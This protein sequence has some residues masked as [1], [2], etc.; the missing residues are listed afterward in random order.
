MKRSL[1]P[2]LSALLT[3][4]LVPA[5]LA[6]QGVALETRRRIALPDAVKAP[7]SDD[8][9]EYRTA[10]SG[11]FT[12]APPQQFWQGYISTALSGQKSGFF[13]A[14]F[15]PHSKMSLTDIHQ[16]AASSFEE[17]GAYLSESRNMTL[18]GYSAEEMVFVCDKG[19][20]LYFTGGKTGTSV[21]FVYV[22]LEKEKSTTIHPF[23]A[24][25]F[26]APTA[27]FE[28]LSPVFDDFV[29]RVTIDPLY[30]TITGRTISR[31]SGIGIA[32]VTVQLLD[33]KT[34]KTIARLTASDGGYRFDSLA[35]GNYYV[36]LAEATGFK[37]QARPTIV[38]LGAG[39]DT[40]GIDFFMDQVEATVPG[41]KGRPK[42]KPKPAGEPSEMEFGIGYRHRLADN[43]GISAAARLGAL[44]PE[45]TLGLNPSGR[46]MTSLGAN[47]F[48]RN[49]GNLRVGVGLFAGLGIERGE[50][51]RWSVELPLTAEYLITPGLSIQASLGPVFSAQGS[52]Q[53]FSIGPRTMTGSLGFTWYFQ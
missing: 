27:S 35:G 34:S 31:A 8:W 12:W 9:S 25:Y 33:S 44:A 50:H 20:G 19:N 43:W 1:K 5:L 14:V 15:D 13:I 40:A 52:K 39:S 53:T 45:V 41:P 37:P 28:E 23:L 32:G 29:R 6:A 2:A 10:A 36:T 26:A 18:S 11:E 51:L 16:S 42:P 22:A 7:G 49:Q 21:S 46:L 48:F 3:V 38:E 47:C 17:D 24:C 4:G 30:G